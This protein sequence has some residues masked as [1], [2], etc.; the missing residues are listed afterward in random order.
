MSENWIVDSEG[1][2]CAECGRDVYHC[3]CKESQNNKEGG[4]ELT[5]E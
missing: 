1:V 3:K 2:V 5:T 4:D